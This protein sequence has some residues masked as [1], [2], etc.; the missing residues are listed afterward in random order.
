MAGSESQKKVAKQAEVQ[1]QDQAKAQGD[2][3]GRAEPQPHEEVAVGLEPGAEKPKGSGTVFT[4][5]KVTEPV[6]EPDRDPPGC[7]VTSTGLSRSNT[8]GFRITLQLVRELGLDP[9]TFAM[10]YGVSEEKRQIALYPVAATTGGAVAV[11]KDMERG[12]LT[13]YLK[14]V[15]KKHPKLK[16]QRRQQCNMFQDIDSEGEQCIVLALGVALDKP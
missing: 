10:E 6:T 12:R 5:V 15:F 7:E 9:E 3:M 13:F 2:T 1:A 14:P 16:V 8:G 11:R 4:R